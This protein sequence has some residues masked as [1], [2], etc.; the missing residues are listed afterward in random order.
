MTLTKWFI[1]ILLSLLMGSS[2]MVHA[3]ARSADARSDHDSERQFVLR[4]R[5]LLLLDPAEVNRTSC[6]RALSAE[7]K[8]NR[9]R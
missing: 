5:T 9:S 8:G 1:L 3:R 7:A 4:S 2:S 6:D